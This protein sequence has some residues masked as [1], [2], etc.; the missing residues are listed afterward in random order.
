MRPVASE[1]T[2]TLRDTSGITTPVTFSSG[3]ASIRAGLASGNWLGMVHL[4]DVDVGFAL[5]LGRRRRA[6]GSVVRLGR[7]GA[8]ARQHQAQD[9]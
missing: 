7:L 4:D 5:H 6:G 8:A 3:A 9:R 1:I 2:G